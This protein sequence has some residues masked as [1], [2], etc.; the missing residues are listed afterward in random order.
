MAVPFDGPPAISCL[1]SPVTTLSGVPPPA[2]PPATAASSTSAPLPAGAGDPPAWT[3]E[4]PAVWARGP[5]AAWDACET[6]QRLAAGEVTRREVVQAALDRAAEVD[7]VVRAMATSTP[8]RAMALADAPGEGR[9]AGVPTA[10]K[11]LH[12]WQGVPT[13]FGSRATGSHVSDH[14]AASVTQLLATG[15]VPIGKATTPEYGMN[16][17][18]ETPGFPPTRNPWD[19][20]RSTGGSSSGSAALVAAGVVPLAKA[21]DGGGSIR[22]PAAACG[23]VGLKPTYGRLVELEEMRGLPIR[24]AQW[25]VITR[26]VRD[27]A[28][29][30]L[31]AEEAWRSS[32]LPPLGPH[33]GTPAMS[34]DAG[35]R[36]IGVVAA[37][38]FGR[39]DA[40]VVQA[41]RRTAE[42]LAALGHHVVELDPPFTPQLFEDFLLY[43]AALAQGI[44]LVGRRTVGRQ[45]DA[46]AL[47][48]WTRGL[49]AHFRRHAARLP[50]AIVR[51]RRSR[52]DLDALLA[53]V[54]VVASPTLGTLPPPIG[55]LDPRQPF[56]QLRARLGEFVPFT[57]AWNVT[58]APAVSVPAWRS[59]E[60]LPIGVQL[61]AGH[62]GEDLLLGLA[63]QLEQLGFN[64]SL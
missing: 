31:A 33:L 64:R 28:A 19:P 1:L 38:P 62:G 20:G 46:S 39:V 24:L 58:G 6:A 37:S 4:F 57:P 8:D 49:A 22:I 18:G 13:T 27:T 25:G 15:V 45:F 54:D 2:Q 3:P 34:E 10:I 40:Q 41:L 23:L 21:S 43:W 35:P 47:D 42:D 61:G 17:T 44:S 50:A 63:G 52:Q 30:L 7:P 56:E 16:P 55:W 14:D 12:E 29:F 59:A 26:S 32:D 9:L 11:D 5:M 53:R 51:L 48:P 36:R 60:G